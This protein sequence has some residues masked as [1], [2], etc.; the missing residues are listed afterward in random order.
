M[1]YDIEVGKIAY[2]AKSSSGKIYFLAQLA[3]CNNV[4][5]SEGKFARSWNVIA[6]GT[7][8]GINTKLGQIA[9]C[10]GNGGIQPIKGRRFSASS[11]LKASKL[12]VCKS[13][14]IEE[15]KRF[16]GTGGFLEKVKILIPIK[17]IDSR[18]QVFIDLCSELLTHE[19]CKGISYYTSYFSKGSDPSHVQIKCNISNIKHADLIATLFALGLDSTELGITAEH[20]PDDLHHTIFNYLKEIDRPSLDEFYKSKHSGQLAA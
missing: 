15:I 17:W 20:Q 5:D 18:K 6:C 19:E 1:S 4:I 10:A 9:E 13:V 7:K 16:S 8:E 14:S 3:G 11:Y 2:Y 12:K